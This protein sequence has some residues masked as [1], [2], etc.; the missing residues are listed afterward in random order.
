MNENSYNVRSSQFAV[1]FSVLYVVLPIII[2]SFGWLKIYFA[3]PASL[4]L[5]YFA[6]SLYNEISSVEVNITNSGTKKFWLLT[7]LCLLVWVFFSGIGRFSYQNWD[8]FARNVF[9]RDLCN[10]EW[11]VIYDFAPQSKLVRSILGD[12]TAALSYY[13]AWWL[14]PAFVSKIF[15]LGQAGQDICIY[16]WAVLGVFLVVYNL[17]R[18]FRKTS[19]TVVLIFIFFSGIDV[20]GAVISGRYS[21]PTPSSR[22]GNVSGIIQVLVLHI[23]WLY[24]FQ[25]SANTTQLYWVFNQSIPVWLITCMLLQLRTNK[26]NMALSS[27]TFAFSS[28]AAIGIIPLALAHSM[29]DGRKFRKAFTLQNIAVPLFM[30][31][32]FGMLYLGTNNAMKISLFINSAEKFAKYLLFIFIEI[33]VYLLIMWRTPCKYNFFYVVVA[34]LLLIPFVQ[35]TTGDFLMRASIPALFIFMVFVIKFLVE[36][37]DNTLRL[38]KIILACALVVGAFTPF[39]EINRSIA[40]TGRYI[41]EKYILHKPMNDIH[42]PL[43]EE[44]YSIGAITEEATASQMEL[45]KNQYLIFDYKHSAFFKYLAR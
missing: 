39:T 20:I 7:L 43:R 9:Y 13:F 44:I 12:G 31:I 16:L 18:Y 30:M 3:V 34:E 35:V 4:I 2:F 45:V 25:Y 14:P 37:D 32:A 27:L 6:Y 21:V 11:P 28:W 23:E 36:E 5:L 1:A 19:Y 26:N 41:A 24:G 17:C 22:Y 29:Q 10:Y 40:G 8:H 38:R 15:S 33:G 42:N